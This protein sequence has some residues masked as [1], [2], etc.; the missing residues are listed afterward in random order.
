M[1]S[2]PLTLPAP[3]VARCAGPPT[4]ASVAG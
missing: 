2:S 1:N 4:V 3:G